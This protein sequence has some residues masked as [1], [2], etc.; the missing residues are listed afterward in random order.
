MS[1]SNSSS[2]IH[3]VSCSAPYTSEISH[4][5]RFTINE[6]GQAVYV[7]DLKVRIDRIP[8]EHV[9]N[10]THSD[11]S[12]SPISSST[13]SFFHPTVPTIIT[14][15]AISENPMPD[16]MS[17]RLLISEVQPL[18]EVYFDHVHKYVPMIHK[19]TFLKQ[20][21]NPTSP[22]SRL[23]LYTMCAVASRWAPEP[24]LSSFN[25]TIPPGYTYYQRALEIIDDF[26]DVPRI[27]TIQA[28]LLIVKYQECFQ[29]AGYFHRSH[30]YLSM[31]AR[32]CQDLGLSQLDYDTHDV[33]TKRRTFW[34]TF[35]YD[36][37]MS[38]EQK[39][40]THF[41]VHECKTGFP[42]VTGEEGPAL[43]ELITNQNIFIQLGKVL[44]D[45]YVMAQRITARQNVQGGQRSTEQTVEEQTRLF[46]L[47]THLENFLYEV[48]PTLIYPPTQDTESYPAD[49]Q[50][51]GDPLL[52]IYT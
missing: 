28:L 9:N 40:S 10:D 39:R 29:R 33:E 26:I 52:A 21:H 19:P 11:I 4:I 5:D 7:N 46:S 43:E 41:K 2:S 12:D 1:C 37:L 38:I 30:F 8:N 20:M 14:T 15:P 35:M 16:Q 24:L 18:T 44:S 22:P 51:I 32:M 48:P 42:L 13:A 36:L 6:I 31:A 47:H 23:L 25:K 17:S 50:A 49:K 3:S 34:I 27:S 45:I